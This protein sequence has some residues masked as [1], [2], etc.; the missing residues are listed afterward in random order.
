[1]IKRVAGRAPLVNKEACRAYAATI[2][3]RLDERLAREAAA[4]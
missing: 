2:A 4:K 3:R 1:M